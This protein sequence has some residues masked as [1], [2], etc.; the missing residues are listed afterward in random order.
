MA[1]FAAYID[2]LHCRLFRQ[3]D[4][5]GGKQGFADH[6]ASNEVLAL[7]GSYRR[8]AAA[9]HDQRDE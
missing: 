5:V 2:T 9:G 3:G 8:T 6:M 1:D 7:G 4:Q